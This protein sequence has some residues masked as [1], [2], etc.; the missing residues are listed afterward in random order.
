MIQPSPAR[1]TSSSFPRANSE[2]NAMKAKQLSSIL[3]AVALQVMPIARVAVLHPA[4]AQTCCAAIVRCL[5]AVA[6]L[7]GTVDAVSGASA[8]IVGVQKYPV[9]PLNPITT[10]AVGGVGA[11]FAY[12]IIVDGA[13][14]DTNFTYYGASP[15]PPG[16]SINTNLGG[17]G[18]IIGT[19]TVAAVTFPVTL[20]A[21]N[22]LYDDLG[23]APVHLDIMIT[24]TN[25]SGTLKP[26]IT[27]QP[28]SATATNGGAAMFAVTATGSPAPIYRWR[29]D[30]VVIPGATAASYVLQP[31][32]TNH[33][34]GYSVIVS[35]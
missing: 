15:L 25:S 32:L 1:F 3:C 13:L 20:T 34:G 14:Q 31:V 26:S 16:L 5:V 28:E 35:N 21:G 12:R 23:G 22:K 29:K 4:G 9:S 27:R 7:L 2:R 10:N 33:A 8:T 30:G 19:A 17:P 24:I 18:F 11:L 6:A